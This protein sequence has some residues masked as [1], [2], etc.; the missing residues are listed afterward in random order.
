MAYLKAKYQFWQNNLTNEEWSDYVDSQKGPTERWQDFWSQITRDKVYS[1]DTSVPEHKDIYNSALRTHIMFG[2]V[3]WE[4]KTTDS[5][6]FDFIDR[7]KYKTFQL[8]QKPIINNKAY[9]DNKKLIT[10]GMGFNMDRPGARTEWE[11]ALGNEDPSTAFD[12]VYRRKTTITDEQA[13]KLFDH[14]IKIREKELSRK[15]NSGWNLLKPNEKITIQSMHYNH[16]SLVG[17]KFTAN[18]KQYIATNDRKYLEQAFFEVKYQSNPK[19][20]KTG[21]EI[22][23][24]TRQAVQERMDRESVMI[25]SY[26][27]PLWRC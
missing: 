22:P 8:P 11:S 17:P 19:I 25:E 18:I 15:F 3:L 26:K 1:L 5:K 21:K 16:P 6:E 9:P 14:S 23:V 27:C 13:Y 24:K 10:V 12:D 4:F 2:E 20:D 7:D